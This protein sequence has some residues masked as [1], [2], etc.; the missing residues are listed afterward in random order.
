[1]MTQRHKYQPELFKKSIG[2]LEVKRSRIFLIK[3]MST[4]GSLVMECLIAGI[5]STHKQWKPKIEEFMN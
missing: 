4:T 3:I 2:T 1:M 5:A